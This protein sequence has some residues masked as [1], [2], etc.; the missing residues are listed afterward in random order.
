MLSPFLHYFFLKL[1]KKNPD[2]TKLNQLNIQIYPKNLE[3]EVCVSKNNHKIFE[4]LRKV[5]YYQK[6]KYIYKN[7]FFIYIYN[8][9][10]QNIPEQFKVSIY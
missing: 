10:K 2:K 6:L 5:R 8:K 3:N 9:T 7:M 4:N 1:I